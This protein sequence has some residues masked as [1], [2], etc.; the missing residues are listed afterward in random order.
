MYYNKQSMGS[1]EKMLKE[2]L[3]KTDCESIK[4]HFS[5]N[6]W[7]DGDGLV[8]LT[9]L[10][11]VKHLI[12]YQDAE[13]TCRERR[14]LFYTKLDKL[15]VQRLTIH[16]KNFDKTKALLRLMK[17]THITILEIIFDDKS[18][19]YQTHGL[20]FWTMPSVAHLRLVNISQQDQEKIKWIFKKINYN[21]LSSVWL[22]NVHKDV[23]NLTLPGIIDNL[24]VS[25]D[26][27]FG[28][29]NPIVI[30]N[31]HIYAQHL[32][33][34]LQFNET[35]IL[36]LTPSHTNNKTH[37][38]HNIV[39]KS[40]SPQAYLIKVDGRIVYDLHITQEN[41]QI[42]KILLQHHKSII[43]HENKLPFN[44]AS[45]YVEAL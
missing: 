2:D 27:P 5:A 38:F 26:F 16:C 15:F 6:P 19:N 7:I 22:E 37:K 29:L 10:R 18:S 4:I 13:K 39:I 9:H 31:L 33:Q 12:L 24:H 43:Q 11:C 23:Q 32:K 17:H 28:I 30:K 36:P 14:P 42:N 1:E 3:I 40:S 34:L 20:T 44:W 35:I 45:R 21:T 8:T 25:H 41:F